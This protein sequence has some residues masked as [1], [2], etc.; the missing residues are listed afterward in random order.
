M[1]IACVSLGMM[2]LCTGCDTEGMLIA[3][4]TVP[5]TTSTAT[6]TTTTTIPTTTTRVPTTTQTVSGGRAELLVNSPDGKVA[7]ATALAQLSKLC[8]ECGTTIA[9]Y[10]KDLITGYSVEYR[11]DTDFQTASVI[12][13]PYVKFLL[14]SGVDRTE[15]LKSTTRQGGSGCVDDFPLGTEFTVEQLM[16]YAIRYS[17]NTAYYMLCKRFGFEEFMEYAKSI[18][19][20]I[21]LKLNFP[22]PRVGYLSARNAG[23]YFEDIARYLENDSPE[24]KLLKQWLTTTEETRQIPAAFENKYTVAHK[25]GAQ[26]NEAYHD[27]AVVYAEKPYVLV[28]L[29]TMT[30]YDKEAI[31]TFHKIAGMVDTLQTAFYAE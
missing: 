15:L 16:E 7:D 4:T 21:T 27:A 30:P 5:T 10:Y 22:K 17:D 2:L 11:A 20:N 6:T 8:E 12:K 26:G 31:A 23:L 18:G 1:R 29:S 13:A 24:A 19:V 28:I 9:A 14:E 3:T 25:Y